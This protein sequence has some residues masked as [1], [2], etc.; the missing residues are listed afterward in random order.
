MRQLRVWPQAPLFLFAALVVVCA[1]VPA[2]AASPATLVASAPAAG[3]AHAV[4]MDGYRAHLD[5]LSEIVSACAHARTAENCNPQQVGADDLVPFGSGRRME[6]YNWLRSALARA[7]A[8][9]EPAAKSDEPKGARPEPSTT[10]DLLA[11]AEERLAV[12][13]AQIDAPGQPP[14]SHA[15]QRAGLRQVLGGSEFR[16]LGHPSIGDELNERLG[17]WLNRLFARMAGLRARSAWLGRALVW[18]F[19]GAICLALVWAL[20]QMERRWR[21][22]L[23]PDERLIAPGAPSARDWRLWLEDARRAAASGSWREAI[24]FLYWASIS[25][26]EAR[27]LWP[28]DRA[29]TPREYLALLAPGDPRRDGLTILTRS[30]ERTWYGGRPAVEGDYQ[31]AEQLATAIMDGGSSPR[32]DEGGAR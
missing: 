21:V 18:G 1:M 3:S 19:V 31:H 10:A 32:R 14:V 29:R 6:R 8:P 11:A 5:Q 26:L 17:N 13:R 2:S 25:R 23:V 16:G 4:S 30:F 20:L 12:D 24:H 27:R 7:A 28:A 22:R 15:Q 9:D